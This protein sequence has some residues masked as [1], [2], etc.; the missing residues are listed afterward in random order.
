MIR[1]RVEA[2]LTDEAIARCRRC[3]AQ[4]RGQ[5]GVP[6]PRPR[7]ELTR[8]PSKGALKLKEIAYVHAEGYAAGEMKHGPIALIDTDMAILVINAEGKIAE[9]TRA[10]I[11]QVKARGGVTI[12]V[13]SDEA[14]HAI[15]DTAVPVAATSEWLSPILNSIPLQLIAYHIAEIHGCDIDKPRNLAKSVTVE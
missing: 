8:S 7:G 13:G 10:N 6:L 9:K 5:A 11:E 1:P 12:S 3:R 4:A 15:A 14:S 2:L